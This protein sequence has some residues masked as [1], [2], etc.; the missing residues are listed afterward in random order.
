M[1]PVLLLQ[2]GVIYR[3]EVQ[4][5]DWSW[6]KGWEWRCRTWWCSQACVGLQRLHGEEKVARGA[7]V[8]R[9]AGTLATGQGT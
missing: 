4:S 1:G 3:F 8:R 9:A 7:G 2:K 5:E 6:E